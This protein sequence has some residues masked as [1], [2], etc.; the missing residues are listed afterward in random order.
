MQVHDAR[1][2]CSCYGRARAAAAAGSL[3][4]FAWHQQEAG[5]AFQ[6]TPVRVCGICAAPPA[7]LAPAAVACAGLADWL[8]GCRAAGWPQ[9]VMCSGR[10][11]GWAYELRHWRERSA[12]NARSGAG[13][14]SMVSSACQ[15]DGSSG[16]VSKRLG[17]GRRPRAARRSGALW[18]KTMPRPRQRVRAAPGRMQAAITAPWPAPSDPVP[19]RPRAAACRAGRAARGRK[20]LQGPAA[21]H[22]C[23]RAAAERTIRCVFLPGRPS[24]RRG[25]RKRYVQTRGR[26]GAAARRGPRRF[27]SR[28]RLD[29]L[30][31][32][33][34]SA[35]RR[36]P[37]MTLCVP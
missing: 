7:G 10:W 32:P 36:H 15:A 33:S 21:G 1:V 17:V 22:P 12:E 24:G 13:R 16:G 8:A 14:R 25:A 18:S 20:M 34:M 19:A 37:K 35:V 30:R 23:A 28:G 29:Q 31:P 5:G 11:A 4:R 26:R 27:V 6:P 9:E 2:E 3:E